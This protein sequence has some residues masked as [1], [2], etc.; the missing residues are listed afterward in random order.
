M[1][2]NALA[3]PLGLLGCAFLLPALGCLMLYVW[4]SGKD[5]AVNWKS[6]E[7]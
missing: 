5:M 1:I 3:I 4:V 7:H 6:W 2:R